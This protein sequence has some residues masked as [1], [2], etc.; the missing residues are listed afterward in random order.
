MLLK[1]NFV[2]FYK[3]K[4][5]FCFYSK[6]KDE[7]IRQEEYLGVYDIAALGKAR[8]SMR[9]IYT[10]KEIT[11]E[12]YNRMVSVNDILKRWTFVVLN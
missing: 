12:K 5:V 1:L 7:Q 9:K 2:I 10:R 8:K 11:Q 3:C 4:H 6:F